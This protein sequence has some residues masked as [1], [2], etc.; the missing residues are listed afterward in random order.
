LESRVGEITDEEAAEALSNAKSQNEELFK[1]QVEGIRKEYKEREDYA[2]MQE[3]AQYEQ[4]QAAA[5]S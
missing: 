5:Y 1:R 4:Q 3:Q 2:N